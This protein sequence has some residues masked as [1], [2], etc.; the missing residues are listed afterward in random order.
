MEP[1]SAASRTRQMIATMFTVGVGGYAALQDMLTWQLIA[2]LI[3][4]LWSY[5]SKSLLQE[6]VRMVSDYLKKGGPPSA[7]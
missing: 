5:T 3:G 2:L 6:T 7:G 1:I 4:C